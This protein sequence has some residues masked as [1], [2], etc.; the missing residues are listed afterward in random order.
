[1]SAELLKPGLVRQAREPGLNPFNLGRERY[2]VRGGAMTV[3]PLLPGDQI[4][5]VDPEGLQCAHIAAFDSRGND[6][7]GQFIEGKTVDGQCLARMLETDTPGADAIRSKLKRFDMNLTSAQPKL[8]LDGDTAPGTRVNLTSNS[9]CIGIIGAPGEPMTVDQQTPPTDLIVWVTRN[10]PTQHISYDL[11]DPLADA[12]QDFR[13]E[14]STATCYEVKA[15]DYIQILDIDGRQCSDFQCFDI[16]ALDKGLERC[17]DATVTRSLMGA[18]YP[19]PGLFSKFF[20]VDLQPV[21]EVVQDTCG[22]HD[23]FGLACTSKTYDEMGYP[24]H[25]NCSDN[26][27]YALE[28]YP[29]APRKG[30]M[31]INLFFNSFFNDSFQLLSDE[32]WSRPGDYVLMRAMRDMICVSSSCSD[33]I[34]VANAWNPTDIQV[35]VYDKKELFKSSIAIRKTTD[36]DPIMTQ[37]TG[38]HS[39]TSKLTRNYVENAGYWMPACYL[40]QGAIEEYWACRRGAVVIDLSALR[41]YEVLGPDAELLLQICLTRDMKKLSVGQVSYT[42]MCNESG[43]MIDDGTVFRLAQQNFRWVGGCDGSGLWLREQAEKLGLKVWVKNSTDQLANLQ[44]QGPDSRKL[45]SQLIWTR[46]DQASVEELGWFRFSVARMHDA[47]GLPIVVS[48]TGYTGELGYEI[49]CHPRDAAT[50]WQMIMDPSHG[51]P[52]TPMGL[53]ALD[54]LRIEAGLILAG[55][56]F[57][58]Q[59]DPFEAGIPFTVP[60]KTKTDNFIGREALEKRKANP[61]RKLVGLELVGREAAESGDGVFNGRY[62]VGD[63]TSST[64]SPI[65]GKTIALCKMNVEFSA[66][67]TEI[68]VGKLDDHQK[69]IPA[70]V[71]PFPH[72]DP[73]KSRV[74]GIYPQSD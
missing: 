5:I 12:R 36:A 27:N 51:I 60:L 43:G 44:V 73:T 16:P 65:L 50:I 63:I 17:L 25:P 40:N 66:D 39:E 26:F 10:S 49:F 74:R 22:R 58:E 29:V 68:E 42:A 21:I 1:M 15:G 41:K 11:P 8:V 55:H 52:V 32:P 45:L 19:S 28:E 47:A 54:M 3:F 2:V 72:F 6:C 30:W 38:F 37:E 59:T 64:V 71:V 24:G 48:R 62:R 14:A 23:S 20:D 4:E 69:R 35:R 61:Q 18:A 33:D 7:S 57:C 34:D 53:D 13:I 9:E 46:P 67:G 70:T 31:A 56:E